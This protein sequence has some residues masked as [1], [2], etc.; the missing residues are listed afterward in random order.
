MGEKCKDIDNSLI[1]I[2]DII[3]FITEI[4]EGSYNIK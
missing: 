2:Y 4:D 1:L 3:S